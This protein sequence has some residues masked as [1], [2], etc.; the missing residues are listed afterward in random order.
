MVAR[1]KSEMFP[2]WFEPNRAHR[3]AASERFAGSTNS[4]LPHRPGNRQG[5]P[6]GGQQ[7]EEDRQLGRPSV[8]MVDST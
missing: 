8:V 4:F 1:P 6:R 5:N 2:N 7:S 3:I